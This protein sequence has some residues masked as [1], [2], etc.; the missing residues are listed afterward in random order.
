MATLFSVSSHEPYIVPEKYQGKFDKGTVNIHQTI[1]YTDMALKK[2]FTAAKKEK[3]YNNTIFVLV[4]DHGNTIAYDEYRKEANKH[5][6]PILF[7]T[8]N[9]KYVGENLIEEGLCAS[10][11]TQW[12]DIEEEVNGVYTY[13]RKIRKID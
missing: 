7:F 13:D 2:F 9:K 11:Y 1:G 6:V 12:S 8:P 5:T 3:W 10:V 4:A